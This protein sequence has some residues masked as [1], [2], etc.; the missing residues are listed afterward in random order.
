MP[1]VSTSAT[2]ART[3]ARQGLPRYRDAHVGG[4]LAARVRRMPDGSTQLQSTEALLPYP[5]RWTDALEAWAKAAPR[6]KLMAKRDAT[7]AWQAITYAQMLRR[8]RAVAQH[9]TTLHLSPERPLVLLSGNDLEHFTLSLAAAWVGVPFAPVSTAYSQVSQDFGKLRHIVNTLTPGLV[10]A[11][12][13]SYAKAIAAV[14]EPNVPVMM[15]SGSLDSHRVTPFAQALAT[16]PGRAV[17]DA[18][19]T[20]SA[21]TILKFMFTS[22]STKDPKAVITTN[23]MLCAN[24]Q[25]IRQCF[26]FLAKTPPVLVDWLPWNHVFGGNHNTGI[27]LYNGGT[28]YIDDGKPT[29]QGML[30]T[31]RNLREISPTIY[32]NVPKGLEEIAR[33]MDSDKALRQRFF[34]RCQVIMY[35]GAGLS[36]AVWDKLDAHAE[37]TVGERVRV[38]SGL[39]M[40]EASP[41]CTFAVGTDVKSTFIG[42]P[43]PGVQAKLVPMEATAH[44]KTE[45]R[46]R[47]PNLMPGYWRNAAATAEAFDDD[48]FYKTGDAV[49]WVNPKDTQQG[50]RFDGRVA[51]DF[52]LATG[53]FVSVG[54][55]RARIV[56]AGDP[57][58]QDVVITGIDRNEVG[59]LVLPRMDACRALA[60]L[61]ADVSAADVLQ[62]ATV[63]QFF[64][65]LAQTMAAQATGSATRVTRWRLLDVPPAIDLGEVTDKGS[66][67]QRAVLHHR[68]AV[69]E[70]LYTNPNHDPLVVLL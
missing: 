59:A 8:V 26:V 9:L 5:A 40:T 30:E 47:G 7:G 66:I 11:S 61:S 17:D 48:G 15:T 27:A 58:V 38:V 31:L 49:C 44:G 45:I 60:S 69:V 6:R 10:F 1:T 64:Q 53:T 50:L 22:G 25:M 20:V 3:P 14:L 13:P 21:D 63:R 28:L 68:A 54:P 33:A 55:L 39:G 56:L 35:A 32:F 19:A 67:N 46:F 43:A 51:E 24:L 57:C 16:T 18:H 12:D 41:S 2:K 42:L 62:H 4:S 52:K 29:P 36:Q 70:A 65:H 23:R 34:K 37:R